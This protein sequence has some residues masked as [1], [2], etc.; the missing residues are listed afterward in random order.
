MLVAVTV[1][2]APTVDPSAVAFASRR[3]GEPWLCFEQPDRSGAALAALGCVRRFRRSGPGRFGAV[4]AAWRELVRSAEADAP[5]GPA[6]AGL[7]AVGGFAF[8]DDGGA[9]RTGP[10]STP[11]TSSCPRWRSRA[12]ARTCG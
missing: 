12:A 1:P 10:A 4:A 6:G 2:V 11:P 7:V 5:D 8:A 9:A 3:P